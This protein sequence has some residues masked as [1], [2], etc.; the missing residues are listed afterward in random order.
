MKSKHLDIELKI[1]LKIYLN[2]KLKWQN[3]LILRKKWLN[4]LILHNILKL[5]QRKK[6]YCKIKLFS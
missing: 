5:I 3:K 1:Q 6:N 4:H 2:I